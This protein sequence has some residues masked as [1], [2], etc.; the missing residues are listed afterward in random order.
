M[1]GA[2]NDVKM[3]LTLCLREERLER[4]RLNREAAKEKG[5][6]VKRRWEQLNAERAEAEGVER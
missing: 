1:T 6:A 2:C 4:T 5:E 3:Q